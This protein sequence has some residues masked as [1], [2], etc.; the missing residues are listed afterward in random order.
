MPFT[1][2]TKD[3]P[4]AYGRHN[5]F[6][7]LPDL[8]FIEKMAPPLRSYL[9]YAFTGSNRTDFL[10][11]VEEAPP[12]AAL[13]AVCRRPHNVWETAVWLQISN[14]RLVRRADGHFRIVPVPEVLPTDT[15]L[16]NELRP[17]RLEVRENGAFAFELADQPTNFLI[18]DR[19]DP[20][21]NEQAL[22]EALPALYI[23]R[24]SIAARCRECPPWRSVFGG[25]GQSPL[26]TDFAVYSRHFR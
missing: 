26:P 20:L 11:A 16:P 2:A 9:V 13:Q 7:K 25:T 1:L 17:C 24:S 21:K 23:C 8:H 12:A 10:R 14:R 19:G 15:V 4:F 22:R 18:Y 3:G 5:S 6:W